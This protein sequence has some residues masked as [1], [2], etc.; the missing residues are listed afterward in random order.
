MWV[1]I[2]IDYDKT[3][4]G[5]VHSLIAYFFLGSSSRNKTR[6]ATTTVFLLRVT[7]QRSGMRIAL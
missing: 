2:V 3:P 1:I 4:Y 6:N 7:S 5:G